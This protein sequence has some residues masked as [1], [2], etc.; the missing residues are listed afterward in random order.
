MKRKRWNKIKDFLIKWPAATVADLIQEMDKIDAVLIFRCLPR[1]F[2]ADV[3]SE[4]DFLDQDALLKDLTDSEISALLSELHPDDRTELF[5]ELPAP[6]TQR[7]LKLLKPEDLKEARVLLGYP[8]DSVGRLMTPDFVSIQ[9]DW[10]V[11]KALKYIR[12]EGKDSEILAM[13]YVVDKHGK[14]LD[15]LRLRQLILANPSKKIS[16]LMNYSYVGITAFEDQEK[17]YHLIKEYNL[18]ALPVVDSEGILLGIV[19]VDDLIDVGE[20]ETTEDFHKIAAMSELKL[21]DRIRFAPVLTL[22]RKRIGWLM[23]LIFV[24]LF[25]GLA[26]TL[27]EETIA[28]YI[29]LLTFMPLLIACGGNAGSQAS[30]LMIRALAMKDV[31]LSDWYYCIG[32][33]ALV[34]GSLGLTLAIIVSFLGIVRGSMHI[35]VVVGLSML[36]IVFIGSLVGISL[37]FIFTKLKWDPAVASGPLITSIADIIGIIIYLF[38][39]TSLLPF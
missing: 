6:V 22:F 19:T 25:A 36:I 39:A 11:K 12:E 20:E 29:V 3:F 35:A 13:I 30:T 27:F 15:E 32:K 18:F 17:A 10:T 31:K 24:N 9:E 2:A 1:D 33:E 28:T 4:V 23:F 14:L 37:P 7:L 38:I 16:E 34:A 26:I 21:P 8:E 5:E